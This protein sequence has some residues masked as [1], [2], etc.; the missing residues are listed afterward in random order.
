ME[1]A[2]HLLRA[3]GDEARQLHL[4]GLRLAGPQ[5][6]LG[7]AGVD[8][9]IEHHGA[10]VVGVAVGVH[11]ADER[12]VR[13]AQV[14][15]L[16]IADGD[17]DLVE[18]AHHG[19]R[20]EIGQQVGVA[21]G[22][23]SRIRLGLVDEGLQLDRAVGRR[24][25]IRET[26]EVVDAADRAAGIHP[27]RIEPDDVEP[28]PDRLRKGGPVVAHELH[29]GPARTARVH[30]QRPDPGGRV[31]GGEADQRDIQ[32]PCRRIVVVAR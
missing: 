25:D 2:F 19:L 10:D 8:G 27:A 1:G 28:G 7:E 12:P 21:L 22:A 26:V 14:G 31:C 4:E 13:E 32:G 6:D 20:R 15:Q 3:V 18:I 29:A 17:A 24:I 30:D 16:L 9:A 23:G 11:R 5:L